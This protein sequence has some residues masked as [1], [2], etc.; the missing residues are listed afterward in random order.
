MNS[1]MID[2]T[3][4]ATRTSGDAT[5]QR[6]TWRPLELLNIYRLISS[7]LLT[8]VALVH[9]QFIPLGEQN[10]ALFIV[11]SIGYL[12]AAQLFVIALHDRA[13]G[14]HV[15]LYAQ[16]LVDFVCIILLTYSSGCIRSGLGTLLIVTLANNKKHNQAAAHE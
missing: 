16:A 15:P 8:F 10:P 13:P 4:T 2:Y 12:L 14:F 1:H 9:V 11:V 6:Q 3:Y 7:A 5:S